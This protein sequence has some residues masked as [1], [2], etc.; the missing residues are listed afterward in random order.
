MRPAFAGP[1]SGG[2]RW[3]PTQDPGK[4]APSSNSVNKQ[5][6][7]DANATSK[8]GNTQQQEKKE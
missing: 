3:K 2:S 7:A 6:A 1:G 4:T 8:G 5:S